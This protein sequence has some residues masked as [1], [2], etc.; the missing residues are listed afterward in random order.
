MDLSERL[1]LYARRREQRESRLREF[2]TTDRPGFLVVQ[3]PLENLL[4]V[5]G[6]C[7]SIEEIYRNNI[8]YVD[9]KLQLDW[10]RRSALLGAVDRHGRLCQR[11]RL[12]IPFPRRQCAAR[13][14]PLPQD[15]RTPRTSNTPT[16]ARAPSCRMVLDCIDCF[17]ERTH[18]GLPIALTDTQSPFDTATLVLDAA[19]FFTACYAEPEIVA[20]FLQKITDL[21]VEFSEVQ[22]R[23]DRARIAGAAGTP[24]AELRGRAGDF[25]F[26]R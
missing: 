18:D 23:A 4:K 6:P 3:H 19:E 13:A 21:I 12:R 16:T 20:G 1:D 8:A 14:I 10:T 25:H 11:L 15:R 9:D 17:R 26:R 22:M 24:H 2:L 7:N 5:F